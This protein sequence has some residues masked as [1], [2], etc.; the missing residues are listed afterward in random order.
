MINSSHVRM[1][2]TFRFALERMVVVSQQTLPRAERFWFTLLIIKLILLE[3][4]LKQPTLSAFAPGPEI[5]IQ[6]LETRILL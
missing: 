4:Q 2:R 3:M 1:N 6:P 5:Y